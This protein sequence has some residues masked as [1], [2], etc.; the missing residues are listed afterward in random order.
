MMIFAAGNRFYRLISLLSVV[1]EYP[2]YSMELFSNKR[3]YKKLV[4][5]LS[6]MQTIRNASTN[7]EIV[8]KVLNVSGKGK[9]KTIRTNKSALKILEWIDDDALTYYLE[10]FNNH[11]FSG[12]ERHITRNHRV[13][14]SACLCMTAGAGVFPYELMKLQNRQIMRIMPDAPSFYFARDIK[15]IGG[16]EMNKTMFTRLTGALFSYGR[17]YAVYNSGD[18]IMKW[19]GMGEIKTLNNL[20]EICRYNSDIKNVDSAILMGKS[21]ETAISTII[22]SDKKKRYELRFDAIFNHIYFVPLNEH[23][24]RQLKIMLLPNWNERLSLLLFGDAYISP[25]NR[26]FEYDAYIDGKYIFSFLDGD[27]ARLI[28]FQE[29]VMENEGKVFEIVCYPYQ[30]DEV[31]RYIGEKVQYKTIYVEQVEDNIGLIK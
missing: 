4:S 20:I 12:N 27:V 9:L 29:T 28:R 22:E 19:K 31:K 10:A 24:I 18:S 15:R 6:V 8:C 25:E 11:K 16:N 2:M 26:V 13:A 3:E 30:L 7:E 21:Y 14:E 1:G 5:N 23:G 17:C